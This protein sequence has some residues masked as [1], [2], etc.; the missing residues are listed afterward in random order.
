MK[1]RHPAGPER[2]PVAVT[3]SFL[4]IGLATAACGYLPSLGGGGANGQDE[5]PTAVEAAVIHGPCWPTYESAV[6]SVSMNRDG[7]AVFIAD[8]KPEQWP[9]DQAW[10]RSWRS[11]NVFDLG[12]TST[13][14][15]GRTWEAQA[16]LP[17]A[18]TPQPRATAMTGLA[19][20]EQLESVKIARSGLGFVVAVSQ[21]G[22]RGGYASIYNGQVPASGNV[23]LEP[24]AGLTRLPINIAS[25]VELIR[26]FSLSP[27]GSRVAAV[28]G[29]L[30]EIRVYDIPGDEVPV[31]SLG[32]DG[33]TVVSHELPD[34]LDRGREPAI[35]TLGV[36]HLTWSPDGRRLALSR[37]ES[38][39]K[40]SLALLEVDTGE[41]VGVA[42]F[43]NSTAPHIAWS[44]DG[45]SLVLMHTPITAG[46]LFGN[47]QFIRL[48]A[49]QDG[50]ELSS[51]EIV[52][53]VG[54]RTEPANLVAVEGLDRFIFNWEH[55]LWQLTATDGDLAG[56]RVWRVTRDAM[57]VPY[58]M[59]A[60]APSLDAAVFLV[61]DDAGFHIGVR[62]DLASETC[63]LYEQTQGKQGG[64][65]AR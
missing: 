62:K 65:E 8:R 24:G 32:A 5:G 7:T 44:P 34:P 42:S 1:V 29:T 58:V 52:R 47:T 19:L 61:Q 31:Y 12:T 53:P 45:E 56:A 36:V 46:G 33:E 9:E 25:A 35:A 14:F 38:S 37:A 49:E 4:F 43:M 20:A 51:G 30:G 16:H 59:P 13:R 64:Q 50:A 54:Y 11:L 10:N 55:G 41:L 6:R 22:L 28:V 26:E 27:E 39:G 2:A 48:M 17:L 23:V 40:A 18:A 15:L 63:T 21:E 3:F 60:V 57:T